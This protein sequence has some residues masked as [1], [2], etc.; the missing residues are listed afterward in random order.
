MGCKWCWWGG[1]GIELEYYL[2]EVC[3]RNYYYAFHIYFHKK[4]P[5]R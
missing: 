2:R 5:C 4:P 3:G 1:G